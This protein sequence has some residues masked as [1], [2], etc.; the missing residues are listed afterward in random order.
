MYIP[1]I[2]AIRFIEILYSLTKRPDKM[3]AKSL[4]DIDILPLS[5]APEI[6]R[7]YP[8]P[9]SQRKISHLDKFRRKN[10]RNVPFDTKP[11]MSAH[12][13]PTFTGF[14]RLATVQ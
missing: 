6:D 5:L 3:I 10:L 7:T 14:C 1:G 11:Q 8:S 13:R 12:P 4:E 2:I 9:L